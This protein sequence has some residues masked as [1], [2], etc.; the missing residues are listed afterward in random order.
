MKPT[1]VA[2]LTEGTVRTCSST[3]LRYR[4]YSTA[5][6]KMNSHTA[7]NKGEMEST[8]FQRNVVKFP[9]STSCNV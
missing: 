3:D 6:T 1:A 5:R 9:F 4:T 8:I 2:I 7:V